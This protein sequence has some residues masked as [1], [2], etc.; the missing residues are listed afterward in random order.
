MYSV[1]TKKPRKSAAPSRRPPRS[2]A[3]A[4]ILKMPERDERRVRALLL[5]EEGPISD[6]EGEQPIVGPVPAAWVPGDRVDERDQPA[7][8]SRPGESK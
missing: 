4:R 3:T 2:T 7:V 5:H 6:G 1:S 8:T